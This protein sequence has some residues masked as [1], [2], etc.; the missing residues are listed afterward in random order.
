MMRVVPVYLEGY[1]ELYTVSDAGIVYS[2]RR[3]SEIKCTWSGRERCQYKS[4]QL[5][6]QGKFKK[7]LLHKLVWV[8]FM[9]ELTEFEQVDHIDRDRNNNQLSNLRAISVHSNQ[10]RRNLYKLSTEPHD[11]WLLEIGL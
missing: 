7:C 9:G 10:A 3:N 5:W 1:Q 4:V 6:N 11:P 2:V 8:S